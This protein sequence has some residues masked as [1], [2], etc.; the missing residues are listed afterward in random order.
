MEARSKSVQVH[1]SESDIIIATPSLN[2]DLFSSDTFN[3]K[4][5]DDLWKDIE[6]YLSRKLITADKFPKVVCLFAGNGSEVELLG[7]NWKKDNIVGVDLHLPNDSRIAM[8]KEVP[9]LPWNLHALAD[10]ISNHIE[11]P[12]EVMKWKN[13]FDMATLMQPYPWIPDEEAVHN[14]G[15]FFV[16]RNGILLI[17]MGNGLFSKKYNKWWK[18][19]K[20]NDSDILKIV[21]A[22][23][24]K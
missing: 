22:F 8:A 20:D 13:S 1:M 2:S 4:D 11:L 21:I 24:R 15:S 14:L 9:W 17:Q 5:S 23:Q 7:R 6:G 18:P 19:Y 10:A 12:T 16:K 3:G